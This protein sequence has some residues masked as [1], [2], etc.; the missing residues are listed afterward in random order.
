MTPLMS[1]PL[2]R[3]HD[4]GGDTLGG[5]PF[6]VKTIIHDIEEDLVAITLEEETEPTILGVPV[7]EVVKVSE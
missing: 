1:F 6:K 3:P 7:D 2:A 4:R 5:G